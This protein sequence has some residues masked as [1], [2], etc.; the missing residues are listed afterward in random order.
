MQY[1]SPRELISN[2]AKTHGGHTAVQCQEGN[3]SYQ[4]L[5]A[6]TANL[7][8]S[9]QQE[10][11][12]TGTQ[13]ALI[14]P[15]SLAYLVWYFAVL[16]AGGV[17]VPLAPTITAMEAEEILESSDIHYLVIPENSALINTLP[18]LSE[19]IIN[20]AD[21]TCLSRREGKNTVN[22]NYNAII[23]GA[24]TRQ[25]SSGSTGRPKHMLKSEY[26]VAHDYWHFCETLGLDSTD[27]FL[28]VTPFHHSYGAMSFLAAFYLGGSV[29]VLPR[30]LPAPVIA[31]AKRDRPTVF[32]ATPPMIDILGSCLLNDNDQESFQNIKACV[33]STGRLS[34][35]SHNT[36]LQRFGVY[37]RVQYGS[38]ETLSATIDMGQH[39]E[40]G[41]VGSAYA[42]VDV[43][44]FDDEGH[45]LLA[46]DRGRIGIS[47]PAASEAYVGDPEN[48]ASTFRNGYVFPGDQGYQDNLGALHVLGR[49]DIINIGGYKVDRL[50]VEMVIRESLPIKDVIVL[51]GQQGGIPVI[52]A[53]IEA[54][55]ENVTRA[56]VIELCR[57]KLS[58]Y[59]IP[60]QIEINEKLERDSNGKVL[61]KYL[62]GQ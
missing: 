48:T 27:K 60:T 45:P 5:A 1:I 51:E 44:I 57:N 15:N 17:V 7:A 52:R 39:Y 54:N 31:A 14:L 22:D 12:V 59:K 13:V 33:C 21:G 35:E 61:R 8:D 26:N 2:R 18:E 62:K 50:E 41:L 10:G 16:E 30:F 53:V 46:G 9:L 47:S 20:L 34:K 49:S 36:F 11:V 38:T 19:A 25:F 40:E 24:V 55:P 28:G 58:S 4:Q 6:K 43:A 3:I 56:M 42:G 37:V 32:L 29:T 23:K